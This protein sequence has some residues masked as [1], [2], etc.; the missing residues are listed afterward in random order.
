[1]RVLRIEKC[2][3][4]GGGWGVAEVRG[5]GGGGG[6]G[7]PAGSRCLNADGKKSDAVERNSPIRAQSKQFI[8][9]MRDQ[10]HMY[11][12]KSEIRMQVEL[13][14]RGRA[15]STFDFLF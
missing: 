1:M 13:Y 11:L 9:S 6:G 4:G 8:Q 14:C 12:H 10:T 15:F 3:A 5:W 7:G 2:R